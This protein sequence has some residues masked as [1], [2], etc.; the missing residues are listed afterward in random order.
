V[1]IPDRR[2]G[3]FTSLAA[4]LGYYVDRLID[5]GGRWYFKERQIR[6]DYVL[7]GRKLER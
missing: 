2:C 4:L 6:V 1:P 3:R 7:K 5:D